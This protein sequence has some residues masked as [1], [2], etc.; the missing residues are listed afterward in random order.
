MIIVM[1]IYLCYTASNP[2]PSPPGAWQHLFSQ[3]LLLAEMG[4]YE[5]AQPA[6]PSTHLPLSATTL[7]TDC[8]PLL[9]PPGGP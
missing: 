8:P 1:I 7:F 3:D 6:N 9:G 4:A 5:W 2:P